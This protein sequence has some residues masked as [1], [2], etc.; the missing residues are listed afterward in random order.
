MSAYSQLTQRERAAIIETKRRDLDEAL[1]V[2][3]FQDGVGSVIRT[4]V[5]LD[6]AEKI[7]GEIREVIEAE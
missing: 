6:R 2:E 4:Y 1:E 5:D 3:F 7:L